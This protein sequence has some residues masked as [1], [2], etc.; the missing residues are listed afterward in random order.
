MSTIYGNAI[1]LP[2]MEAS[3][4]SVQD[5]KAVTITSNGTVSVT[6]DAPYDALKKV[7]VTVDVASGGGEFNVNIS[8][9]RPFT[10]DT[11]VTGVM[12]KALPFKHNTGSLSIQA[13]MS[14]GGAIFMNSVYESSSCYEY[15]VNL[16]NVDIY[17]YSYS[18]GWT[19]H[20]KITSFPYRFPSGT[21]KA[22]FIPVADN[23]IIN[24][25]YYDDN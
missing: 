19:K 21:M 6:P 24:I 12:E 5:T 1:I 14:E 9:Q 3:S 10:G 23:A 13:K 20:E 8:I 22:I 18:M 7:D 16:S 4:A 2:S 17:F 25:S 11:L 15:I